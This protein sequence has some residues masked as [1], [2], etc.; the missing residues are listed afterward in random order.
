MISSSPSSL[1]E[2][3]HDTQYFT[4]TAWHWRYICD[5]LVFSVRRFHRTNICWTWRRAAKEATLRSLQ[6]SSSAL[7][8][9]DKCTFIE[10]HIRTQKTWTRVESRQS[11]TCIHTCKNTSYLTEYII[12]PVSDHTVLPPLLPF[13]AL[14]LQHTPTVAVYLQCICFIPVRV[15]TVIIAVGMSLV[16]SYKNVLLPFQR[17]N[18]LPLESHFGLM[19]DPNQCLYKFCQDEHF[20]HQLSSEAPWLEEAY[21]SSYLHY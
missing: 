3:A 20:K 7:I 8:S 12:L 2:C 21:Q 4:S 11:H 15:I 19:E 14:Q 10:F 16:V 9:K 6:G 5:W 13:E 17:S 1:T 18:T